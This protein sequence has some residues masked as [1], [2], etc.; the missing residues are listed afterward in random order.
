MDT[1]IESNEKNTVN[2]KYLGEKGLLAFIGFLSAFIPLSTDLYLPSL[3]TM[4]GNFGVPNTL[5]NLTL[6]L[7]FIFFALGML[8]WGPL[9][10]KY[11]RKP[12]LVIG[13]FIYTIASLLCA[14]S[15]NVYQL[16]VFRVFQ[17]IGA[18]SATGVSTAMVKDVYEGK[19]R[20]AVLAMVQ[21]MAMISPIVAP[22]LGAFI[23]KFVSWRGAF[24]ALFIAG[25]IGILGG[26]ALEETIKTKNEG[27]ILQSLGRLK[28]VAKNRGFI[29]LVLIFAMANIPGMAY[30]SASSYIYVDTFGLS[31]QTY[32][33]YFAFNAAFFV[34]GPILYIRISR[35]IKNNSIITGS[36]FI[37]AISGLLIC[38]LG[39][40]SPVAFA[41]LLFPA[42]LSGSLMRPPTT[43][44]VIEQQD[45]DIGSAMSLMSFIYTV[46]GS[47]GMLLISL[48]WESTIVAMGIMYLIM[49]VVSIILWL[50][51]HSKPFIRQVKHHKF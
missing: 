22:V 11:G 2:Q 15:G 9:S 7:F 30:I 44:L 36:Y 51:I 38:I 20:V 16:I 31:E 41:L 49:A 8:V 47:I 17:A 14:L 28:V 19:K 45:N 48:K 13:M 24:I 6:V 35:Y 4:A 1:I 26:I 12:I 18:G 50:F 23:I 33:Y 32:S 29:Y 3:P 10:D 39:T 21:S 43:N 40:K 5:I 37:T 25:I 42:S 46:M 34:I 27:T